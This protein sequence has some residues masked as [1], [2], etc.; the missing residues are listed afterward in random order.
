MDYLAPSALRGQVLEDI[1]TS[2]GR[3]IEDILTAATA[4]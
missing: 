4:F 1:L 2:S 3:V